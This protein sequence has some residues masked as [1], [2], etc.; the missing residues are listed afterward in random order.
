MPKVLNHEYPTY[1]VEENHKTHRGELVDIVAQRWEESGRWML[2]ERSREDNSCVFFG[3]EYDSLESLCFLKG[4][5][6][7]KVR[8]GKAV[9]LE[10]KAAPAAV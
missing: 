9:L 1:L 3:R 6:Y 10:T 8:F 5:D 7:R 2:A 4:Y